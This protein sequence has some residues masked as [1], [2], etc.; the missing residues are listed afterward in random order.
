M[1]ILLCLTCTLWSVKFLS[2][3]MQLPESPP[4][5]MPD[6]FVV[7][8]LLREQENIERVAVQFA[9]LAEKYWRLRL[10]LVTTERESI[11]NTTTVETT[12]HR[13]S[14]LRRAK[15]FPGEVIHLHYPKFNDVVADQLNYALAFIS[16]NFHSDDAFCVFYNADSVV[17]STS[18]DEIVALAISRAE[19]IQQ[20]SFFFWNE[21]LFL[22]SEKF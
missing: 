8:P 3:N 5:Q 18:F 11:E 2:K 12:A 13:I 10:V 15:T 19:T 22:F 17:P 7:I 16:E 1:K 6:I 21:P 4:F 14:K 20:S 9:A